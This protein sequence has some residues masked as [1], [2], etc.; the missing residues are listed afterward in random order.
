MPGPPIPGARSS[1]SRPRASRGRRAARVRGGTGQS[2]GSAVGPVIGEAA[3]PHVGPVLAARG[4]RSWPRR[5]T[6]RM[7]A[8]RRETPGASIRT[9]TSSSRPR[10]LSPSTSGMT[11]FSH[12][13]RGATPV[14]GTPPGLLR[15]HLA[16]EGVAEAVDRPHVARL[17]RIVAEGGAATRPPPP[18]G[19]RPP[20]PCPATAVLGCAA[21]SG[22]W[23][24]T[25]RGGPAARRPWAG[26][27]P[28]PRPGR[29]GGCRGP[30][31]TR[32]SG[33]SGAPS[34]S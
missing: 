17:L 34:R 15:L 2:S 1:S 18:S 32:R 10:T 30:G 3:V 5:P 26:G 27:A 24:G 28:P 11:R 23:G 29:A 31:G 25:G 19:W 13:T 22:P 20:P 12:R 9:V 6:T 14:E 21:C 8:C 33:L 16:R 4:P 7:R